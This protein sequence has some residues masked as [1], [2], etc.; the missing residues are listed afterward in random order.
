[1][2]REDFAKSKVIYA[3]RSF[4]NAK[5][6][7]VSLMESE[8]I[9]IDQF[10]N[11]HGKPITAMTDLLAPRTMQ[12]QDPRSGEM[13]LTGCL[14]NLFNNYVQKVNATLQFEVYR[15]DDFNEII[16]RVKADELDMGIHL[17]VSIFSSGL[18][19]ASYPFL[20]TSYCLMLQVPAQLPVNMVYA[21]IVD[22][23]VL[24]IIFVM[25][26]LL[27]M[28]LVYSENM[29]WRSL[30]L[31][32]ILLNDIS[33]RGLLGQS[34]PF[35]LNASRS[36][37]M[38]FCILCFASIMMTTMYNAYLQS[39]FTDPPTKAPIKSFKDLDKLPQ[40][41][42]ISAFEV[43]AFTKGNNSHFKEVNQDYLEIFDNWQEY[44][45]VREMLNLSYSYVSSGDRW[46]SIVEQQ[47]IFKRPAFYFAT[48]LCFS[49]LMFLSI[50]LRKHLPYR[51]LF[52]EHILRQHEFGLVN[53]WMGNS[54]LDKV[55][56]GIT[57]F[58]D[59]SPPT[60]QEASLVLED[61]SWLLN[62]YVVSMVLSIFCFLVEVFTKSEKWRRWRG[63]SDSS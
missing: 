35:P 29:S 12:Y 40:K 25:F 21:M 24:L 30:T 2:V 7:E 56:L 19:T 62:L 49:R 45:Y 39:F 51:H 52:E 55:R 31:S 48:D 50:P 46:T 14:G 16:R 1:M 34:H 10:R 17:V 27:S 32:T 5:L 22:R 18:D 57:P 58:K 54:F 33:L 41:I 15:G 38:I 4:Q 36:F 37:R 11:M 23:M 60:R 43:A 44:V 42:A 53:H 8:P 20:L 9:Y 59:L 26:C 28:L 13:K 63:V 6:K 3:C 61:I 47:K